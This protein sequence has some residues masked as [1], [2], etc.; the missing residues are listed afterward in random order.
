MQ[1]KT[2]NGERK[3]SEVINVAMIYTKIKSDRQYYEDLYMHYKGSG[4][5]PQSVALANQIKVV[6]AALKR[7]EQ[8]H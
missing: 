7:L 6:I 5:V 3:S 2:T 1:R 4:K 8:M